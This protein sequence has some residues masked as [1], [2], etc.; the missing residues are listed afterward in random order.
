MD[1]KNSEKELTLI[2]RIEESI[3]ET[4]T[5]DLR[6]LLCDVNIILQVNGIIY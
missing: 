4:P 2:K 5:G 6:N 1:K 3:L